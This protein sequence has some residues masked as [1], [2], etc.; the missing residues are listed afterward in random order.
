MNTLRLVT[1]R[2]ELVSATAETAAAAAGPENESLARALGA[3]V[4]VDWPPGIDDDGRMA[5]EGF[6]FVRDLLAKDPG[7]IG[8][9]GWWV[10]LA[11]ARPVLIGSVSPKGPPD[12][13]GT[14]E[15][16]YGIVASRQRQGYA[17][18]ATLALIEWLLRDSRVRRIVAETFPHLAASLAVMKK[19]GLS[20]VGEGSEPGAIRYGAG[21]EPLR[22]IAVLV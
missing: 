14:A 2:L 12:R 6:A 4:P 7:L 17:T 21:A 5:R 8:W 18:E 10:V 9:W 15:V 20:F 19:C 22:R 13:E 3:D 16:A 1:R 11:G